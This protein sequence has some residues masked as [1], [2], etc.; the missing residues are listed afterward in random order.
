[1]QNR[2][3]LSAGCLLLLFLTGT[4]GDSVCRLSGGTFVPAVWPQ[5]KFPTEQWGELHSG[6]ELLIR[7]PSL[8]CAT[9]EAGEDDRANNLG[10]LLADRNGP[11][12]PA[13]YW[14]GGARLDEIEAGAS[15][16][17]SGAAQD[18][19]VLRAD[20][21]HIESR[22]KPGTAWISFALD[23]AVS[24]RWAIDRS[25]LTIDRLPGSGAIE[26]Q[27]S[28]ATQAVATGADA[29]NEASSL[30]YQTLFGSLEPRLQQASRWV[31]A[32]DPALSDVPIGTLVERAGPVPIYVVERHST[33][34]VAG[35]GI[36]ADRPSAREYQD[37]RLFLG[38]GDPIYNQADE[39]KARPRTNHTI[40][41]PFRLFGASTVEAQA[42]LE[43]PRL[44]GTGAELVACAKAW[45]GN[46]MVLSGKAATREGLLAAL[47]RHPAVVH[48]A[49]HFLQAA[50]SA[51]EMIALGLDS[52]GAVQLIGPPEIAHNCALA[53][54]GGIGGVER[55]PLGRGSGASRR[56]ML[57]LTRTWILAR[58][59]RHRQPLG[60]TGREWSVIQRFL[61]RL[62]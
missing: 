58:A 16:G 9:L 55:L 19:A 11:H 59:Q 52:H 45:R 53:G 47:P 57:G 56:G 14:Q 44:V 4:V 42:N 24:W 13:S 25:G 8:V 48:V 26:R 30:L 34:V 61:T 5:R 22:L 7:D 50:D 62:A 35:A 31:L 3:K 33:V 37:D 29:A 51:D 28:E 20:L 12:M 32:L 18:S 36:W 10:P 54:A 1:M 60:Y 39:R 41:L 27:A 46:S 49:A 17:E 40:A 21:V 23:E 15:A 38:I 43:L 2:S 6:C